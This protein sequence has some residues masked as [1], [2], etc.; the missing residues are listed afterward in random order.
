MYQTE[1]RKCKIMETLYLALYGDLCSKARY[2]TYETCI[3]CLK[4]NCI[5][6]RMVFERLNVIETTLSLRSVSKIKPVCFLVL[7]LCSPQ[8]LLNVWHRF[9]N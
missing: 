1:T 9:E 4:I 2:F 8:S 7:L 3:N 5:P 6:Q